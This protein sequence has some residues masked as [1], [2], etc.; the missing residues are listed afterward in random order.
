MGKDLS[1]NVFNASWQKD[2]KREYVIDENQPQVKHDQS[3]E[4]DGGQ[5]HDLNSFEK[6]IVRSAPREKGLLESLGTLLPQDQGEDYE[7]QA[8]A[9]RMKKKSRKR[10]R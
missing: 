5:T 9:N 8:F 10:K 2:T 7:E 3:E 1:A 4:I 6:E